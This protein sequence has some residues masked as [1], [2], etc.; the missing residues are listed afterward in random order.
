MY[1]INEVRIEGN[2]TANPELKALPNGGNVCTFSIAT[3]RKWK[4]SDGTMNEDA[5]FHNIVV[6]GAQAENSA[7]YLQKGSSA[8]VSGRLETRSWEKDEVKHYRTEIVGQS[9]QFGSKRDGNTTDHKQNDRLPDY[10]EE[11]INPEDIPF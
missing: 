10:P 6:Y 9:I 8:Y 4:G 5:Q 7:K 11:E 2:L 3:N 1:N